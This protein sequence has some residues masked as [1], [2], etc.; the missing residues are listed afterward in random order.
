MEPKPIG[1]FRKCKA[2]L[3]HRRVKNMLPLA[4]EEERV[5]GSSMCP[6]SL[7]KLGSNV[8]FFISS[9]TEELN[10]WYSLVIR[11]NKKSNF[12]FWFLIIYSKKMSMSSLKK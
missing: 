11:Q 5:K 7:A 8:F 10:K 9:K 6:I 3:G 12:K 4:W 1:T 2:P